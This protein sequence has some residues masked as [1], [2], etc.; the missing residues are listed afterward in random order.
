M[1]N[2]KWG[3]F[4]CNCHSK[5]KIKQEELEGP[6]E[7]TFLPSSPEEEIKEFATEVSQRELEHIFVGC[8]A[9]QNF[10]EQSLSDFQLHYFDMKGRCMMPHADSQQAHKK[11]LK[12]INAELFE[13][14]LK[15]EPIFL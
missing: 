14:K 13:K 5:L 4:F 10:F 9:E 7:Y 2:S 11:A 8:C 1:K 6:F 3:A 12:M 15:Q